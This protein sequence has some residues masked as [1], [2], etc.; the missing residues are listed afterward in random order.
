MLVVDFHRICSWVCRFWL[1]FPRGR[2]LTLTPPL[3]AARIHS[4]EVRGLIS[5]LR[6]KG[7][8]ARAG[9]PRLG[10]LAAHTVSPDPGH[11]APRG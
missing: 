11:V 5:Q 3:K 9:S 8:R 7:G 4:A 10:A 2:S 1:A 6:T